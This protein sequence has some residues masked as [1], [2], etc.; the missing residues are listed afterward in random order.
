MTNN[1][2]AAS[3]PASTGKQPDPFQSDE[4]L[5]PPTEGYLT[6]KEAAERM[7]LSVETV[8]AMC[9]DGSLPGA[10]RKQGRWYVPL[11]EV[12]AWRRRQSVEPSSSEGAL[13]PTS[14]VMSA[15]AEKEPGPP[16]WWER[17]RYNSWVFYPITVLSGLIVIVGV[18][19]G[20]IQAGADF[21]GFSTQVKE[22]GLVREFPAERE[23]KTLIVIARFYRSEG[24]TD[25]EAH[26]EIRDAIQAAARELGGIESASRRVIRAD[27]RRRSGSG[28][29]A[30]PEV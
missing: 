20:L 11:N 4:T 3:G 8:R 17:F 22:W 7:S 18:L 30:G 27:S 28:Q 13:E 29:E 19:F 2:N 10:M 26:N 14:E 5:P 21:G 23:G 12:E 9:N 25:T 15:T 1:R 6:T 24:V 16:A